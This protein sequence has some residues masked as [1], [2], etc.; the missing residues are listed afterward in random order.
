M[1]LFPVPLMAP[2]TSWLLQLSLKLGPHMTGMGK[3]VH[4]LV[5]SMGDTE[6]PHLRFPHPSLLALALCSVGIVR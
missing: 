3:T 1:L 2:N 4:G 5:G 6:N